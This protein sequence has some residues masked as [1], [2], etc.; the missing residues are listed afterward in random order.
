MLFQLGQVAPS[1][2]V[3]VGVVAK[4]AHLAAMVAYMVAALVL[5]PRQ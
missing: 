3:A 1:V 2:L 4:G 5:T